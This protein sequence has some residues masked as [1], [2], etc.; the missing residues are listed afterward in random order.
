MA[1]II[2]LFIL[3]LFK[4]YL[5]LTVD[6]KDLEIYNKTSGVMLRTVKYLA[7]SRRTILSTYGVTISAPDKQYP[8]DSECNK[9]GVLQVSIERRQTC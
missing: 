7:D 3:F 5:F 6:K 8:Y 2:C 9:L 4:E 1:I